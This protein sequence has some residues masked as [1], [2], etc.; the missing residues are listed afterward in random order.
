MLSRL[1]LESEIVL[2]HQRDE[3][4]AVN[5]DLFAARYSMARSQLIASKPFRAVSR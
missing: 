1:P 3:I 2:V 5:G 4:F